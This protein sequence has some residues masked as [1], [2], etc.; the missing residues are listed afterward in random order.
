MDISNYWRTIKAQSKELTGVKKIDAGLFHKAGISSSLE[1][2]IQAVKGGNVRKIVKA[3]NEAYKKAKKYSET[4]HAKE[5]KTGKKALTAK[6]LKSAKIVGDALDKILEQLADVIS[7]KAIA[8]S[9]DGDGKGDAARSN[10][11]LD[12]R[13][14]RAAKAH[15][16]L[17]LQVARNAKGY[18][19]KYKSDA[20][21]MANFLKLAKKAA[22][23]AKTTKQAGDT[24]NNMQAQDIAS[25]ALDEIEGI[26][27]GISRHYEANINRNGSDFMNARADFGGKDDLPSWYRP[28][29]MKEHN[30]AWAK[31][32]TQIGEI[33]KIRN[34]L[35]D[36]MDQ[37]RRFADIAESFSM[38]AV[39][40]KKLIA[41]L[42][43]I[44]NDATKTF[45]DVELAH[46]RVLNV[47]ENVTKIMNSA[48]DGPGKVKGIALREDD[49]KKRIK[50][51]IDG[52]KKVQEMVGRI[53]AI[54]GGVEDASVG[55]AAAAAAAPVR[56]TVQL[57][58]DF[59][60]EVA[61]TLKSISDA[62][63]T[64]SDTV[65]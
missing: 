55:E 28:D 60:A 32:M 37:A 54:S 8:G 64:L 24:F 39:D 12:P 15:V 40:P 48:L 22:A 19:A 49:A 5:L 63:A 50:Q 2:Y 7:G 56:K 14:E 29:Y 26:L 20:A 35:S 3:A 41:K 4:V 43:N 38:Q 33:D 42:K 31:V 47:A 57:M 25:R 6:Q 27:D 18:V 21:P 52:T 9:F 46:T 13:L 34:M 58:K 53:K 61:A 23:D 51:C 59:K 17:R 65:G 10:E 36:V 30:A 44:E 1:E 16:T 45:K 11:P 62:K